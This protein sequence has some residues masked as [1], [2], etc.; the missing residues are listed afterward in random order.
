M[1][2]DDYASITA[3]DLAARA[4]LIDKTDRIS[5]ALD[6]MDKHKVNQLLV[7][8]EGEIVGILTKK[9]IART[10]GASDDIIKPA[11][12]LHVTKAAD[13]TFTT[14]SGDLSI[15]EINH[16]MKSSEVL[17]VVCP[18]STGWITFNEI[19]KASRPIGSAGDIMD[20]PVTCSSFDRVTHVRRR[21]IDENA[22]WMMVV[23]DSKLV[24]IITENDIAKAMSHFRDVVSPHYQDARV[25]KLVVDDIM[26][27][28]IVFVRTS[29]PC[30]EAVDLMLKHDV[31]GVPV[32]DQTD[33]MVGM[34]TQGTIL[35][36]LE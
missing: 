11:S 24:G 5:H 28:D 16:L 9:G 4:Y 2:Y 10:L 7:T 17:V 27:T 29:T 23:E 19:V 34:I 21:M 18:R 32:L 26:I 3:S 6:L 13:E 8:N 33:E 31:E 22:W 14:V 25:R 35:R 1:R 12:S 15:G 30:I 36:T 20:P